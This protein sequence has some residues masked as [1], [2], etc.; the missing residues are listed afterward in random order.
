MARPTRPRAR[1]GKV[2]SLAL[3]VAA[4]AVVGFGLASR[5]EQQVLALLPQTPAGCLVG[6]SADVPAGPEAI[7]PTGPGQPLAGLTPVDTTALSVHERLN[8]ANICHTFRWIYSFDDSHG[9]SEVWCAPPEGVVDSF[10]YQADGTLVVFVQGAAPPTP[11]DQPPQG[12][13]CPS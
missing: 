9:F 11:R 12:W 5:Q 13:G 1:S 10:G 8:A 2:I 7:D 6:A 3:L 4:A